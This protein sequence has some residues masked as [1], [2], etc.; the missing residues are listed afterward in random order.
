M[1]A[2]FLEDKWG[3]IELYKKGYIPKHAK[4]KNLAGQIVNVRQRADTFANY[5]EQRTMDKCP[6]ITSHRRNKHNTLFPTIADISAEPF[7]IEELED[8]IRNFKNN[9]APGPSGVPIEAVKLLDIDSKLALLKL[10]NQCLMDR[11]VT[12]DMN[13]ADLAVIFNKGLTDLPV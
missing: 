12:L 6:N 7:S 3:P 8:V 2:N 13:Q 4:L 1:I 11:K 10:M 9:N 5:Y